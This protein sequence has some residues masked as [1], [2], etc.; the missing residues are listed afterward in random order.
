MAQWEKVE[1]EGLPKPKYRKKRQGIPKREAEISKVARLGA[2][3]EILSQ[4]WEGGKEK[5]GTGSGY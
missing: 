1:T 5:S 2:E 3:K 4:E